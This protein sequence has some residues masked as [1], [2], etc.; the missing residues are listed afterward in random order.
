MRPRSHHHR[1]ATARW[2]ALLYKITV[3][4][5]FV[6][7]A[8]G[9]ASPA[10]AQGMP[11][12]TAQSE[13]LIDTLGYPEIQIVAGPDGVTA[14][15][16][17]EAGLHLVTLSAPEPYV[18]YVD[19]MQPPAGMSD[20]EALELAQAA[21]KDD[22]AQSGWVYAGGNNTFEPGVPVK[23][24]VD[25]APGEYRIAASYYELG[26]ED[27]VMQLV[28]LT[29]TEGA[30]PAAA[31]RPDAEVTLEM[32]DE[33]AY[34]V[35]PDPVPAGPQ[36]W[37]IA[38]TGEHHAHHAV[39]FRVPEGVTADAIVADF[40]SLMSGT[41]PAGP[42]LIAQFTHVGYAALQSGGQTT[43]IELDLAPG[44]Y[45]VI[46]FII[47]PATGMPHVVNGMVTTFTVA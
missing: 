33:L 1:T 42:P 35:S 45:A 18:A 32:T 24:I 13:E 26:S 34:T 44:T 3:V 10:T 40:V 30:T 28:P 8:A 6:G 47:D 5:A 23:F 27:E 9:A 38:N 22:L 17:L 29:V 46:C 37:E 11:V 20:A 16:T 2:R 36:V 19:F 39:V 25:L 41:P 14:P 43:W 7:L 21:A 31:D 12:D 4:L 15:A